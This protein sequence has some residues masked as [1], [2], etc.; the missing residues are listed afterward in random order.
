VRIVFAVN[1]V[2]PPTLKRLAARS[3]GLPV[4]P[5]RL[6][7]RIDEALSEPDPRRA[8]LEMTELQLETVML[9][10]DTP[11]VVRARQWLAEG[12]ELLRDHPVR[13]TEAK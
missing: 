13:G 12:G 10:P 7:E 6:A 5:G 9:A 2:W 1:R 4:K 11:N 3:A 8:L